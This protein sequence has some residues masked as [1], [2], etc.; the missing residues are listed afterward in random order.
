MTEQEAQDLLR[1]IE[2]T[3]Q[4]IATTE[5]DSLKT[6]LKRELEFLLERYATEWLGG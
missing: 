6:L 2:N 1:R 4:H 3:K 5:N